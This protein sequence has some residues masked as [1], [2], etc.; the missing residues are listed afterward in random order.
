M[1]VLIAASECVPFIKTGGLADVAGTLPI[2]LKKR[3]IQVSVI[4][5]KYHDIAQSYR[6][7]MKHV[8]NFYVN[9]GWRRQ[10]CDIEM[11]VLDGIPYYFVAN[12][13]YFGGPGVYRSGIEEGERYAFFCRAVLEALP[14]IDIPDILHCNDWQTA[15]I[16]VLLEIQ[17]RNIAQYR[18]MKT[19]F[20]IHNLLFQGTF[21]LDWMEEMLGL[22]DKY[23]SSDYLEYFGNINFMKGGIVFANLVTT[24]SPTYAEEIQLPYRGETLDGIVRANAHKLRGILNG[25]DIKKYNPKEDPIIPVNYTWRSYNRKEE[26]KKQLQNELG[27]LQNN[28]PILA[29]ISRLTAQKGMDLIERVLADIMSADVQLVVLGKGDSRYE[30]LFKWA[31]WRYGNMFSLR[32]ELNE[33]LAHRIYAGADMLLMPSEFEPCGLSQMIAMQYGTLPIVRETGG[34]KDT[35]IPYN[36]YT[37]KGNGFS[38]ANFNAHEML[39][40]I[41]CAIQLYRENKEAWA[42]LARQAMRTDFSWDKSAQNYINLYSELVP[43]AKEEKEAPGK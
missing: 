26:N 32:L 33:E 11:L 17:Y 41:N 16:P 29:I 13:F 21:P 15:L 4:L 22:D 18:E 42:A 23:L 30:D 20:T 9:L 2:A 7:E 25:I 35:V 34:L 1:K 14:H 5:P 38:F 10:R 24:V 12:E 27:L 19:V 6:D 36:E 3:G 28:T 37:G 40:V 43:H 39:Y 8:V 31:Q